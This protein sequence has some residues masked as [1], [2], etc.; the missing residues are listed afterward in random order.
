[1][2]DATGRKVAEVPIEEVVVLPG[3]TRILPITLVGPLPAGNY[4]A[5]AVL[6]YGDPS[7]DVAADLPFTLK[8]PLAAPLTPPPSQEGEKGGTP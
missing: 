4:T 6:N 3:Q 1:M 7:R 5:L 8:S 2:R